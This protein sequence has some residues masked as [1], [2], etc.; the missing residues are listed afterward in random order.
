MLNEIP[1]IQEKTSIKIISKLPNI[2]LFLKNHP[3]LKIKNDEYKIKEEI[4]KFRKNVIIT[5]KRD[6]K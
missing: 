1:S 5:G 4:L 2:R 6:K 3:E